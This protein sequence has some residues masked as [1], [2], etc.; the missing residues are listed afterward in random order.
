MARKLWFFIVIC[1]IVLCILTGLILCNVPIPGDMEI[2]TWVVSRR[3]DSLTFFIEGLT[4]FSSSIPGLL[5]TMGVSFVEVWRRR[6]LDWRAGWATFAYLGAVACN[7]GLRILVGR[8]RPSVSYIPHVL[9]ELQASFQRFCYPSGHAG[10]ALVAFASLIVLM[11]TMPRLRGVVLAAGILL[12]LGCGYGRVYMGVHW[13]T[14]VLAGYLLGGSW[15]AMGLLVRRSEMTTMHK[16]L[17]NGR[18]QTD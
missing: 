16:E 6:R 12:I 14:D 11:W 8:Q 17:D 2:V 13:P 7:I 10:A 1:G 3:N 4:F 15:L 5:I 9:P 18:N